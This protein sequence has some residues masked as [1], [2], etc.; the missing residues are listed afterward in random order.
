MQLYIDS[1]K[2]TGCRICEVFC[3]FKHESAIQ[4]AKSRIT[5]L[6]DTEPGRFIPFT[7]VQCA[8]PACAEACP[9][10]AITRDAESGL[11]SVNANECIGCR[12]CVQVNTVMHITVKDTGIGIPPE[13]LPRIF[14][15][16]YV[17]DASRSRQLGGTG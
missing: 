8:R 6:A 3:S 1:T 4:P 2:C 12:M 11:V 15:R 7:C 14:E 16:F 5:V 10:G 9:V 17:V 13:H